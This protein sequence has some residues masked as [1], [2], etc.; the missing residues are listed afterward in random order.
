MESFVS[1]TFLIFFGDTGIK[2]EIERIDLT[3]AL[4]LQGISVII[5][6]IFLISISFSICTESYRLVSTKKN[7]FKESEEMKKKLR[8]VIGKAINFLFAWKKK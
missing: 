6:Y 8:A 5:I 7:I 3:L 2:N 1:Y 4:L